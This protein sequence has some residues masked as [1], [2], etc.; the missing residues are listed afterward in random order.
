MATINIKLNHAVNVSTYWVSLEAEVARPYFC[1]EVN[2]TVKEGSKQFRGLPPIGRSV[3]VTDSGLHKVYL[4]LLCT[5]PSTPQHFQM[6][7]C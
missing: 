7:R 2:L 5:T 6:L 4:Q 3:V 1:S